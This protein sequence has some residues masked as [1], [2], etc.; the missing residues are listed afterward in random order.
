MTIA[1]TTATTTNESSPL[2]LHKKIP[3]LNHVADASG[4]GKRY[5]GLEDPGQ[6]QEADI[7][8]RVHVPLWKRSAFFGH[9]MELVVL[10]REGGPLIARHSSRR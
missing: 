4:E 3:Y 10:N 9:E 7:L 8:Q 5:V 1:T 6:N 2:I